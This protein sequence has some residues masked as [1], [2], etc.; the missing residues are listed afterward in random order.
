[1]ANIVLLKDKRG[2]AVY[3]KSHSDAIQ[4]ANEEK[5]LTHEELAR[6][7]GKSQSYV[8]N[9]IGLLRLPEEVKNSISHR[10][11]ALQILRNKLL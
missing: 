11:R 7:L 6:V 4:V 2:D 8:T 5:N 9:T 10:A 3:P 1:M